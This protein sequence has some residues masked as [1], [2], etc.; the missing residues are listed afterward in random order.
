MQKAR[1][2]E[3]IKAIVEN[4][5]ELYDFIIDLSKGLE[6]LSDPEHANLDDVIGVYVDGPLAYGVDGQ[7]N[8]ADSMLKRTPIMELNITATL[9]TLV[10]WWN[11]ARYVAFCVLCSYLICW[12]DSVHDGA[13]QCTAIMRGTPIP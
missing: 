13:C 9:M 5:L 7:P 3:L 12:T 4:E 8:I 6:P 2:L 10:S 1:K 11:A